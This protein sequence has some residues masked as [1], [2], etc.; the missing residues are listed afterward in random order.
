M[1]II[2]S[3]GLIHPT[4]TSNYRTEM[5]VAS[6]PRCSS[7]FVAQLRSIKSGHT[8]SCGCLKKDALHM[9]TTK[10]L[11]EDKPRLYSIWKN[12]KT[13]CTNPNIPQSADWLGR[14]IKRCAEWDDFSEF[15]KW[16]IAN[17][18]SDSLS[19]DRIDVNG[20]YKP[21]NCRWATPKEQAQNTRVLRRSNTSGFRGVNKSGRKFVARVYHNGD[22]IYIGKFADAE[23]AAKAYD[24][25]VIENDVGLPTNFGAKK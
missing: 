15:Y 25:Y 12:M 14:G 21:S 7:E 16:S 11:R 6:C 5:V 9:V 3:L 22:R 23:S 17:G 8:K 20:D 18:Y 24:A 4:A 1:E 10:P 19:I 2:R 13:R